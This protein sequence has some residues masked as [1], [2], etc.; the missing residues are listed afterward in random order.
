MV[1]LR[2][3]RDLRANAEADE[4]GDDVSVSSIPSVEDFRMEIGDFFSFDGDRDVN[5]ELR[6]E[7]LAEFFGSIS[8]TILSS[9]RLG[10]FLATELSF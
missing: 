5:I 6:R 3:K 4:P 2:F 8:S 7:L 10:F 9:V 1:G